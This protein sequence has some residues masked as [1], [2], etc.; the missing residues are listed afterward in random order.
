MTNSATPTS[1]T[2][3][4][5]PPVFENSSTLSRES[6]D[7]SAGE[8]AISDE[9]HHK[10]NSIIEAV[11]HVI[12]LIAGSGVLQLPYALNQSGW[13]GIGLI[14]FAAFA[15]NYSGKLLVKC[16]YAN[17]DSN[18]SS[19]RLKGFSH[20]GYEAFGERGRILVEGFTSAMLIGVPIVYLILSGMNLELIFGIYSKQT[21]IILS[22]VLVMIPFLLFKTLKEIAIFSAFGVFATFI[23]IGTVVFYSIHDLPLN[24]GKVTHKF[25][26]GSQVASALG[27]ISFSY[28]GNYIYPEVEGS[29]ADPKKFHVVLSISMVV[30]SV[31]YLITAILGYAAYGNLTDSPILNNL[32]KGT[33]ANFS[34]FVITAHVLLAI[35]VVVTTF[36]LEMERKLDLLKIAGGSTRREDFYRTILR[37]GIIGVIVTLAIAIPFFKDFMT[38]LGAVANTALI[39]IFPVIFDFKLFGFQNRPW[40]E[41]VFGV[42]ILI[43]GA[44]GGLVGGYEAVIALLNDINGVP[45]VGGG[46]HLF[47]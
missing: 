21:W 34:I 25:F 44:F 17:G 20:I 4:L 36:S 3:L 18:E 29:M 39:F 28:A 41:R 46:G 30:I 24:A 27:S 38:L 9:S 7:E 33:I 47:W 31:M 2:P 13:A 10:G 22:A 23:V 8:I 19:R 11:Y 15:N 42:V 26:D 6:I 43:V 12:C 5:R 35:P 16:L 45:N 40:Q 37:V 32:P 1:S 14:V